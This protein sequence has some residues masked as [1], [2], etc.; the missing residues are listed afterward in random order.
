LNGTTRIPAFGT[1]LS[2]L[3]QETGSSST[4]TDKAPAPE[5]AGTFA[6]T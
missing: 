1:N 2:L 4:F 6:L 3:A 5:M